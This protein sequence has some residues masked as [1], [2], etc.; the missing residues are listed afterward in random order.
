M[1][2]VMEVDQENNNKRKSGS[3]E[4]KR[5]YRD[6][7]NR[8]EGL[9][10]NDD[11][12]INA[13][14]ELGEILK[15]V[16]LIDDQCAFVERVEY[17]DETLLESVVLSS[18]SGIVV[19]CI[20]SLDIFTSTYEPAE[21]ASKLLNGLKN[22]EEGEFRDE[23]WLN[24]LDDACSI[25]PEVP[26][27]SFLYGSFDPTKIPEPKQRKERKRDAQERVEKKQLQ[28][29]HNLE[30]DE[31]GVDDTVNFLGNVLRNEYEQNNSQP[32]FYFDFVVDSDNFGATVENIF[33][34]S[35]LI[36][37]GKAKL[38]VDNSGIPTLQPMHKRELK[39][40]RQEGGINTQVIT[41]I[42]MEDWEELRVKEGYIQKHRKL[43]KSK[44]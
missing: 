8:I 5:C 38:N 44:T 20:E 40:F 17:A 27:F 36:R 7:L 33:Y 24:I 29:I 19:K 4:R 18:A 26:N 9:Q 12:G 39:A 43:L 11:V 35:F 31:E 6:L 2:Q 10:E 3:Y 41:S 32:I 30:Q 14:K 25:V 13:V 37:D 34:T 23:D 28:R 16:N 1:L 22:S 42:T 21:F 15:E